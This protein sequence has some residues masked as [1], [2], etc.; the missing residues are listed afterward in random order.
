M[1]PGP[2]RGRFAPSP[3]GAL[4]L[5]NAW[6]ALCAFAASR[7]SGGTFVLR[8]E[9]LDPRRSKPAIVQQQLEDLRWL[10]IAWDEGPD[11]GGPRAPYVQSQRLERYADAL[12]RLETFPCTCTRKEIRAALAEIAGAPHGGGARYPGTCLHRPPAPDRP[13]ARRWLPPDGVVEATC[14]HYGPLRAQ[15]R[16]EVGAVALRRSDGVFAYRLAVVVDDAEMGIDLVVRGRDLLEDTP[17][18]VAIARALGLVP[19]AYLH[20]PLVLG[21]EGTKLSKRAGGLSLA[22]LRAA[23]ARPE[24][25]V[26]YLAEHMGLVPRDT[27]L[28]SARAFV[29]AFDPSRLPHA[30]LVIDPARAIEEIVA[31]GSSP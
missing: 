20:V 9:D 16:R 4:H 14:A 23:G 26:A 7:R 10:G 12:G 15:L 13:A 25:V 1:P 17:L 19:P 21:P 8:V 29:D 22:R 28:L 31:R 2:L 3:T 11:V 24:A 18:Q 5:G 6:A 30:D 27:R